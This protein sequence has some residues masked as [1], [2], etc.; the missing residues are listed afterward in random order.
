MAVIAIAAVFFSQF[1]LSPPLKTSILDLIPQTEETPVTQAA[2]DSLSNALASQIV[3]LVPAEKKSDA[4]HAADA[5]ASALRN[6]NVFSSVTCRIDRRQQKQFF[7]VFFPAR[8]TLLSPENRKLAATR[9]PDALA[10]KATQRLYAMISGVPSSL[11]TQDPFFLFEDYMQNLPKLSGAFYPSDDH[12]IHED[13]NLTW[14]LLSATGKKGVFSG[15]GASEVVAVI[16]GAI[17]D[18]AKKYPLKDVLWTG[19]ARY[20]AAAAEGAR[21]EISIIGTGS[22]LG[23]VLLLILTFSSVRELIYGLIPIVVGIVLASVTT[24]AVFGNIHIITLVFGASLVGVCIDYSFHYFAH[25]LVQKSAILK[26]VLPGITLGMVTSVIGYVALLIAPFPGLQQMA[27][28]A[29]V[30]LIGAYG[31]VVCWFPLLPFSTATRR[32]PRLWQWTGRYIRHFRKRTIVAALLLSI[33][34]A[35]AIPFIKAN[36]DIRLL[37][38]DFPKLE[39]EEQ[40]ILENIGGFDKSRF[41]VLWETSEES[42][43]QKEERVIERLKALREQNQLGDFF[44]AA[45]LVPSKKVQREN[46]QFL[47]QFIDSAAAQNHFAHMGW[48]K[49]EINK[50]RSSVTNAHPMHFREIRDLDALKLYAGLRLGRIDNH[51]FASVILLQDVT[52][53][54]ALQQEISKISNAVYVDKVARITSLFSQ[55]R[56]IASFLVAAAYGV[57]LIFLIIRYGYS[58]GLRVFTPPLLTAIILLGGLSFLQVQVNIFTFLAL[59]IV[60]AIGIDYTL[61]FAESKDEAPTAFAIALSG[62]TTILSFGLLALSNN[63]ALES[64]GGTVLAG[65]T[66]AVLLS[67]IARNRENHGT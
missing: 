1:A 18:V 12:L 4:I 31:T 20:A 42:L 25:N 46:Q 64:F 39:A 40:R 60:L 54:D 53:A 37:R 67:P 15:N 58:K 13:E 50:T 56:Q 29:G 52:D 10:E 66:L 3:I 32:I 55:Y 2:Y 16:D 47:K 8:W 41:L 34:F 36:D 35:V 17:N 14:V 45:Q 11:I 21:R 24:V 49:N 9:Q 26:S 6:A 63:P 23:V 51:I 30:G 19:M 22:L 5:I 61:F 62:T 27:V 48:E 38:G 43:V 28:F 57:I 44:S 65:I 33:P 59:I 7:D